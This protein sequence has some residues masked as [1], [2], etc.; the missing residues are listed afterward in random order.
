F[1]PSGKIR[2]KRSI[3]FAGILCCIL[4]LTAC[5][6]QPSGALFNGTDNNQWDVVSG[7]MLIQENLLSLTGTNTYALLKDG[8]YKDFDLH[9]ELRTVDGGKGFVGIHTDATGKGYRVAINN[10]REDPVWW[11]MTGSLLSV[12]NLTKSFVKDNEWFTMDIR[13]EGKAIT[14]K[15]NGEPVVEYIEPATPLRTGAN[16]SRLLGEGSFSLHSNGNGKIEFK[17]IAVTPLDSRGIDIAQQQALAIDEQADEIIRLHQEDFPVLDY[18]VHLKGGLTK[19]VAAS[20]SRRTGINY[21]IA[22]NCG[23]GFPV[24]NDTD[25]YNFLDTMRA[26]PF[27]LAMQAE[28]REWLTT[29]SQ[30]A[31]DEFD[32]VFTDAL[33]FDDHKGRRTRLW[34]AEEV[35]IDDEQQYM[36][37]IVDRICTVLQEPVD[38]YVNPFYL[39]DAL[40]DRYD[41][42]WTEQRIDKVI[43]VL[44]KS[45]KAL[46]INEL[47]QI[48]NKTTL[49]KA[50]EAGI[51]FTFGSNNVT[52]DV[53]DLGYSIRMKKKNAALLPDI[54]TSHVL[55]Y[56]R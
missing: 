23:I 22:P 39:P 34:I 37:M 49:L 26:Q 4:H 36:D 24:T 52:P 29:F 42:F 17:E 54:C 44:A 46:E 19:E 56:N 9:M 35:F 55:R 13:V 33:T 41:A 31:R 48:P 2:V 47:Y 32:Y 21:A 7:E 10:D 3:F 28:G 15:I 20:Q 45:G 6:N 53:S 11:R 25:I 5:N 12:R 27:I 38:I 50:K 8:R 40:S 14:V 16:S 43:A 51:K 30:A 1:D 18:H